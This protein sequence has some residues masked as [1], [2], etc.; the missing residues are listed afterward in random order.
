MK[1]GGDWV[2]GDMKYWLEILTW[3]MFGLWLAE[4]RYVKVNGARL[5]IVYGYTWCTIACGLRLQNA[6]VTLCKARTGMFVDGVRKVWYLMLSHINKP[7][8]NLFN[9]EIK[10]IDNS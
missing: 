5:C 7:S 6:P 2:N 8:I 3:K 4:S 1:C 10:K 9:E